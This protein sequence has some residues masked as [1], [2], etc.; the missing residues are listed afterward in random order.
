MPPRSKGRESVQTRRI[1]ACFGEGQSERDPIALWCTNEIQ[2]SGWALDDS[3]GP[4]ETAIQE[5]EARHGVRSAKPHGV[6]RWV[7]SPDA[8]VQA[9]YQDAV[10]LLALGLALVLLAPLLAY[11]LRAPARRALKR[12]LHRM[13]VR[14]RPGR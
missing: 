11:A 4:Y 13:G 2:G 5:A 8:A 10:E 9:R 1:W 3:S 14:Y 7:R 12:G 6:V